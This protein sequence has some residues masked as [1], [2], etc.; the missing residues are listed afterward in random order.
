MALADCA[1]GY[2]AYAQGGKGGRIYTVISS[3]DDAVNPKPGTLRYGVTLHGRVWIVFGRNMNIVLKMPLVIGSYKTIDGRGA[4][5]DI[6]SGACLLIHE[7]QNVIIHGLN[8]HLCKSTDP[9]YVVWSDSTIQ[10]LG[11]A[12]GDGIS[13]KSSRHIWIDHNTLSTCDDGLIDVTLGSTYVTISNNWFKHHNLVMLLGHSDHFSQD[14][15]MRVTIAY[16]QFGPGCD[17]RMP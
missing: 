7:V 3:E 6:S 14:K 9:G 16:N 17:E 12:D 4:Q 11:K 15:L 13:I 8:I 10:H 2:G 1:V 5:V